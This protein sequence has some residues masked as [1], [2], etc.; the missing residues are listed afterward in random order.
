M[1]PWDYMMG[2]GCWGLGAGCEAHVSSTGHAAH[3]KA[4]CRLGRV[5]VWPA[6]GGR[7]DLLQHGERR[8]VLEP[9]VHHSRPL[10]QYG[11]HKPC[12]RPRH[13]HSRPQCS[14]CLAKHGYCTSADLAARLSLS[15][16]AAVQGDHTRYKVGATLRL[17]L[18]AFSANG[19]NVT[20]E[21]VLAIVSP[22]AARGE[23]LRWCPDLERCAQDCEAEAS[24]GSLG[25]STEPPKPIVV[26]RSS[27]R[28]PAGQPWKLPRLSWTCALLHAS[29]PLRAPPQGRPSACRVSQPPMPLCAP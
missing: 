12:T 10:R 14:S 23:G 4:H 17:R 27:C 19:L 8:L 11:Q 18:A 13:S 28:V 25:A 21:R 6:G 7:D 20:A 2:A 3:H 22:C 15:A 9:T 24:V 1:L 29:Q 16:P 5:C 26:S